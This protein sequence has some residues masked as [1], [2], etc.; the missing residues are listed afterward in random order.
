MI[1]KD[2][3]GNNAAACKNARQ[4]SH[5]YGY[6]VGHC[7]VV[8]SVKIM[9]RMKEQ[10][11]VAALVVEIHCKDAADKELEKQQ[12]NKAYNAKVPVY[13]RKLEER[14]CAVG[15]LTVGEI[16]SIIFTIYNIT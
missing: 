4:K 6:L 7:S 1:I 11:I 9:N 3:I 5:S 13:M 8:N 15:K 14:N 12:K 10:L 16:E 2:Y